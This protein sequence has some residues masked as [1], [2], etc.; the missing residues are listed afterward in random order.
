[1]QL[2]IHYNYTERGP[3]KVAHNLLKGM[4]NAGLPVL[5][6]KEG[7][8]NVILQDCPRLHRDLKNCIIGPNICTLPMDSPVVLNSTDYKSILVP[9]PWVAKLYE[10]WLPEKK[11]S[12]WPV[13]IDIEEFKDTSR[14]EKSIDCLLYYK[15]RSPED[16]SYIINRLENLKQSFMIVRYG[17]YTEDSFKSL[18][19]SCRYAVSVNNTESQGIALQ[20]I[21]SSGLPLFVWDT[22]VWDHRGQ[23]H[24]VPATSV[25]YWSDQ[26][27]IKVEKKEDVDQEL[28]KFLSNLYRYQP[29]VFID[30]KLNLKKQAIKLHKLFL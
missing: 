20:E 2:G 19:E 10:K 14:C 1:M 9:S 23:E 6:N 22:P 26:C 5:L 29:R 24:A 11:I 15:N 16:L 8:V 25:P 18:L 27:G 4:A 13:G 7:D 30:L 12:T 3:G 28:P 21:L 17:D